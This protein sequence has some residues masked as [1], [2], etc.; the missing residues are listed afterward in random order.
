MF[1]LFP[2]E[3]YLD[4]SQKKLSR[5]ESSKMNFFRLT[6]KYSIRKKYL[7]F[8]FFHPEKKRS[9]NGESILSGVRDPK[10]YY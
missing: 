3:F 10:K 9:L 4:K 1:G 2:K 8:F 5:S 7:N 6:V